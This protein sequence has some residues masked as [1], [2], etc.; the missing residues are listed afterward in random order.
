MH[1]LMNNSL[2]L[3]TALITY[4]VFRDTDISLFDTLLVLFTAERC[5]DH[6]ITEAELQ[7]GSLV[8]LLLDADYEEAANVLT[9]SFQLDFCC[10]QGLKLQL[11]QHICLSALPKTFCAKTMQNGS[12]G[13]TLYFGIYYALRIFQ[14]HT[15]SHMDF[16]NYGF[17]YFSFQLIMQKD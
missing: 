17:L 11:C 2:P 8:T 15:G 10:F 16:A 6:N 13:F 12:I 9:L 7:D 14:G 5:L 4:I 1:L 3:D